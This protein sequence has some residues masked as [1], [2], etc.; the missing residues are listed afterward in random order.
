[1]L[2]ALISSKDICF[3]LLQNYIYQGFKMQLDARDR[4]LIFT[5][6]TASNSCTLKAQ[7]AGSSKM[8]VTMYQATRILGVVTYNSAM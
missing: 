4:T 6:M 1:M 3:S 5:S 2:K 8:L 7:P